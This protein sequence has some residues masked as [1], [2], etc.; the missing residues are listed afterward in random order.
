M[1]SNLPLHFVSS[2]LKPI[3]IVFHI[4]AVAGS[5]R[6]DEYFPR[7]DCSAIHPKTLADRDQP[8]WSNEVL[9]R[10]VSVQQCRL[11][12]ICVESLPHVFRVI[13][14]VHVNI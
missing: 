8:L 6:N 14:C 9:C 13:T 3:Y 11:V 4:T 2:T 12:Y 7:D 5:D 10:F 1:P